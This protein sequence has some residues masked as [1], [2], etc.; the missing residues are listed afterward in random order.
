M[1]QAETRLSCLLSK[2]REA[3]KTPLAAGSVRSSGGPGVQMNVNMGPRGTWLLATLLM[4]GLC[5]LAGAQKPGK[6]RFRSL[7]GSGA[8]EPA[9]L[10]AF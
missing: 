3:Y 8:S 7:R 4:L 6:W 9:S 1:P 2:H 10:G 5:A